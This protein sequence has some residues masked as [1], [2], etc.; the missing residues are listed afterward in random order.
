MYIQSVVFKTEDAE[1]FCTHLIGCFHSRRVCVRER[2][3]C[4]YNDVHK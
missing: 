2:Q 4:K 3:C 1:K